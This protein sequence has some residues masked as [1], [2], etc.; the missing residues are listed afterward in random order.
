MIRGVAQ[1]TW[2]WTVATSAVRQRSV[3]TVWDA[4]SRPM[5]DSPLAAHTS[6]PQEL[7]ARMAAERDGEPF[8]VYRDGDGRQ[9]IVTL[10]GER[11]SIGRAGENAITLGW[12]DEVS[13]LHAELERIGGEWTISDAGLSRN[14]TFIA[15]LRI[16]G[17]HR[18]R[19]GDVVQVGRGRI[20]FRHPGEDGAALTRSGGG[21][22][23]DLTPA[24]RAVLLALARP[25]G[26]DPLAGPASNREIAEVLVLSIDAVK[27]HLR[28]LFRRFGIDDLPQNRKR[29]RLVADAL[30]RGAISAAEL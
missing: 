21:E 8:L 15:G 19:D 20:V 27:S 6:T 1:D 25:L 16:A 7:Q 13:R 9:V 23:P 12:D 5:T 24:Q 2:G 11:L 26:S 10:A 28:E 29:A 17:R 18:L 3:G 14:G 4:W 22:A 30:D